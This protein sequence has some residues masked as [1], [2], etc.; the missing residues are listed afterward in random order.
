MELKITADKKLLD[1]INKLAD[2]ILA[3]R[4][5]SIDV[6]PSPATGT[7]QQNATPAPDPEPEAPEL[8]TPSSE[9]P[10]RTFAREEVQRIG[11]RKVQ[12]GK[13]AD[14]KALVEKYGAKRV[15]EIPEDKLAAFAT[16]LEAL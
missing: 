2:A 8:S 10:A 12:E 16:E 3:V 9:A 14:V 4:S 1:A 11:I 6:N 15:G 13:R 5:T 7:A